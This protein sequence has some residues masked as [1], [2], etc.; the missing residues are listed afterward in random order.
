MIA[1]LLAACTLISDGEVTDKVGVGVDEADSGVVDTGDAGEDTAVD[2]SDTDT[3]SG[4]D[5]DSDADG[6]PAGD[7]D[8]DD[9][10]PEVHPGATEYCNGY[11]DNCDGT[12]DEGAAVDAST[13]YADADTDTYGDASVSEA[14]CDQPAGYVAGAT[15]CDD[16]SPTIYPAAP[17]LSCVDGVVN[18]CGTTVA[19][20]IAAC[21]GS[22]DL[23]LADAKFIGENASD[24]V[25]Y[26]VAS[27]GDVNLDGYDD[28]IV[29]AEGDDDGGD[30]AGAAYLILGPVTGDVDLS[31][32]D[33]KFIGEDAGDSAG[34]VVASACDV[35]G[36]G[37]DDL[38]VAASGDDDGG[39]AAGAA[40]LI[41]GP[42]AGDVDLSAADAKFIGEDENDSAGR[43][44]ASAGDV[45][46]DGYDDLI[47][48]ASG[49]ADGGN[50]A[51]AAYLILGPVA[52]DVDLS[53]ANAKVI[54]EDEGDNAGFSVAPAGD[55]NGDGHADLIVGASGDDDGGTE[56]GAAYLILTTY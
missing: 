19:A 41:L 18:D 27:A 43:S 21:L 35:N 49:D 34:L 50:Y 33:A 36:D 28:L 3:D 48:G 1:L 30:R 7:G 12:T 51:G 31:M 22:L 26:S 52:G 24:S 6:V 11:D 14:A 46:G 5:T 37:Y 40:Y 55:V 29:G 4:A 8:C 32:A 13:W 44:V 39:D 23:S 15:D 25:G 10:N 53:L 9:D 17:E 2:T 20:A 38:I 54:G 16:T 47:V 56:A 45:N 42:V